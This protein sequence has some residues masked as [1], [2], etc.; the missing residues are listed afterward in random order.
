MG[1]NADIKMLQ[2]RDGLSREEAGAVVATREYGDPVL[3]EMGQQK[4]GFDFSD[5]MRARENGMDNSEARQE[6]RRIQEQEIAKE[7]KDSF[8]AL[9]EAKSVEYNGVKYE[10]TPNT[11]SGGII[12]SY[13]EGDT[14]FKL[15]FD[16]DGRQYFFD[17]DEQVYLVDDS[18]RKLPFRLA[19]ELAENP[20]SNNPQTTPQTTP[21]SPQ[22]SQLS[23]NSET[24]TTLVDP[25]N[26]R[27]NTLIAKVGSTTV[28][29]ENFTTVGTELTNSYLEIG[30]LVKK[31]I[32]NPSVFSKLPPDYQRYLQELYEFTQGD[33]VKRYSGAGQ[34]TTVQDVNTRINIIQQNTIPFFN[35][36]DDRVSAIS[37]EPVPCH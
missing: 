1:R 22:E 29:S 4:G 5:Y 20:R 10:I 14:T 26:D 2:E 21:A 34:G 24:L 37:V 9:I 31:I 23:S 27:L 15:S 17:G 35:E 28:T 30:P 33:D 3:E 19:D 32:D 25:I 6:A 13:K 7:N 36:L 18:T 12:I 16:R 11:E 8:Q